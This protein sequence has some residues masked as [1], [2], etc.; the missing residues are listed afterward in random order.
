MQP[1]ST[2]SRSSAVQWRWILVSPSE[3]GL[4]RFS[5]NS[6]LH[7]WDRISANPHKFQQRIA[8]ACQPRCAQ[9][10]MDF[11]S[12]C[13]CVTIFTPSGR[14]SASSGPF[15]RCSSRLLAVIHLEIRRASRPVPPWRKIPQYQCVKT[16]LKLLAQFSRPHTDNLHRKG[17]PFF[18]AGARFSNSI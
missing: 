14:N 12:S 7:I 11:C 13:A 9:R 1:G 16:L 6:R 18:S 10:S 8:G 3:K 17:T 4:V 15:T 5:F 2:A